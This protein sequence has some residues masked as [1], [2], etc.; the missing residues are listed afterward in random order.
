MTEAIA[1]ERVLTPA[2]LLVAV[3][4]FFA[5]LSIGIVLPTPH[6]GSASSR[7][8]ITEQRFGSRASSR[9]VGCARASRV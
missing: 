2:F 1:H 3:A 6:S 5:F 8:T 9:A 4:T 7:S